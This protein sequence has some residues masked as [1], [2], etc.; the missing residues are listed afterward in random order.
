MRHCLLR[1]GNRTPYAVVCTGRK[2]ECVIYEYMIRPF[3]GS[4]L[5]IVDALLCVTGKFPISS[6]QNTCARTIRFATVFAFVFPAFEWTFSCSLFVVSLCHLRWEQVHKRTQKQFGKM[7]I[8]RKISSEKYY[9]HIDC[10]LCDF[11]FSRFS[12][13]PM[14]M[15]NTPNYEYSALNCQISVWWKWEDDEESIQH[16]AMHLI[17][18]N[19]FIVHLT[20]QRICSSLNWWCIDQYV[21]IWLKDDRRQHSSSVEC[22]KK[23]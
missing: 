4:A 6:S 19:M 10:S 15:L 3:V 18:R 22:V 8:F 20:S 23:K 7:E 12:L 5:L 1:I 14:V 9:F 11:S 16:M 17:S 21:S 2:N 13:M